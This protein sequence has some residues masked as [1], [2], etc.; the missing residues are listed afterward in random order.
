MQQHKWLKKNHLLLAENMLFIK[1]IE[2][3]F[4]IIVMNRTV[5]SSLVS[6]RYIS[7][8]CFV[9]QSPDSSAKKPNKTPVKPNGSAG[10]P[11]GSATKPQIKVWKVP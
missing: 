9:F 5:I 1:P 2:Y 3:I 7:Q 6:L 8:F 4:W 11:S 10:K